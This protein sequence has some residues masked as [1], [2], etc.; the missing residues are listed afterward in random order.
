MEICC[1]LPVTSTL[2]VSDRGVVTASCCLS[3]YRGQWRFPVPRLLHPH[4]LQGG[5][6]VFCVFSSFLSPCGCCPMSRYRVQW[7]CFCPP[8]V[9]SSLVG[10]V[11]LLQPLAVSGYRV[12][13]RCFCAPPVTSS[14]VGEVGLLQP[15]AVSGHRVQRRCFCTPPVP[16]LLVVSDRGVAADC[17]SLLGYRVKR[18]LPIPCL[19]HRDSLQRGSGVFFVFCHLNFQPLARCPVVTLSG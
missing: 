19:L 17:F 4:S 5:S 16:S 11:G 15:L 13:W 3:G 7:R 12:Q 14:F 2:V 8:P 10:E 9:T 1:A 18:S 6:R